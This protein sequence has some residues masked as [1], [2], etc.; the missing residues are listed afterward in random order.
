MTIDSSSNILKFQMKNKLKQKRM[1]TNNKHDRKQEKE[2][3]PT[4]WKR[5]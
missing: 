1:E 3:G 4:Y 5:E 2:E